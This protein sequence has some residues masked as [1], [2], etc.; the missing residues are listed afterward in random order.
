M[1]PPTNDGFLGFGGGE[2]CIWRR[3]GGAYGGL[4]PAAPR[5]IDTPSGHLE[6]E[7]QHP[8][9]VFYY[10]IVT[11]QILTFREERSNIPH[12]CFVDLVSFVD[13]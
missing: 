6:K 4:C 9:F 12:L 2:V 8:K 3:G 1:K 13:M 5:F 10:C 11:S 7:I